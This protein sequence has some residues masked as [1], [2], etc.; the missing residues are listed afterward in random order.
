MD[1]QLLVSPA[2]FFHSQVSEATGHLNLNLNQE[3]E[4]Y[5]VRLLLQFISNEEAASGVR[6]LDKTL[7]ELYELAQTEQV[8]SR[9]VNILKDLGDLSLYISGFF[10]DSFNRKTF[11]I[12]Y[13]IDM[14]SLAYQ[15]ASALTHTKGNQAKVFDHLGREFLKLVD[16]LAE[17]ADLT[18]RQTNRDILALYDRYLQ[19]NSDRALRLLK[20]E[21]IDPLPINLK[22]AQ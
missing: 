22:I 11:N 18:R 12:R 10:Q 17:I 14:G 19:T 9:K 20:E 21:G 15:G 4:S 13:Y 5:L 16:V 8:M 6:L 7:F 2:E 1:S 3:V